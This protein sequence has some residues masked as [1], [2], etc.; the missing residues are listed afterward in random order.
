MASGY[1]EKHRQV[2]TAILASFFFYYLFFSSPFLILQASAKVSKAEEALWR[3]HLEEKK[4]L[5]LLL[6]RA[7]AA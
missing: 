2:N 1:D 6:V 7:R 4:K 5:H 3:R